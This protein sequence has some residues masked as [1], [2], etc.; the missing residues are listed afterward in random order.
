MPDIRSN[1]I[2]NCS[3][4]VKIELLRRDPVA[5]AELVREREAG[6]GRGAG[7]GRGGAGMETYEL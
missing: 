2:Q 4:Y 1:P 7:A 5:P 6:G 3:Q